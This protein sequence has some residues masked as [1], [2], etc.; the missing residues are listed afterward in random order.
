[1]SNALLDQLPIATIRGRARIADRGQGDLGPDVAAL[2][3]AGWLNACLPV[4][5]GGMGWS[6]EPAGS[7]PAFD[8]LRLAGRANLS[9]A[10]LF[11]GHMNAVKLVYLYANDALKSEIAAT[12]AGGSLLG[13]WGADV[14]DDP[15]TR[16]GGSE[17][18]SLKGI[19]Q[20]ASGL[21]LVEQAVIAVRTDEGTELWLAPTDERERADPAAW[22]MGGMRATQSGRYDFTGITLDR[23]SRLGVPDIYFTEPY[24]EGGIWRYCAAHLGAA[25]GI[26]EAMRDS[27]M[28]ANRA[29]DPHQ[30][31]RIAECA[32]ALETMRLWISRAAREVEAE[33]APA[34]KAAL[35]LLARDV[36][37]TNCLLVMDRAERALGTVAYIEGS[38]IERSCR[39]L[40]LFLRQAAPDAKRAK[41]VAQLLESSTLVEGL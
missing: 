21:N 25:E 2:H 7:A 14:P 41:A 18:V 32:I 38:L 11:E 1:M 4:R 28:R 27:L 9:L 5:H 40:R 23:T 31:R 15:V 30:Q 33:G 29:H 3:A 22:T 24:F 17:A 36:T 34:G 20:F 16:S 8:A 35:S 37:E 13:V 12:V 26:Y 19:K 6:C 39:D 10:R